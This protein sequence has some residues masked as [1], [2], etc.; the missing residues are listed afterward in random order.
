[1]TGH[2]RK[3]FILSRITE[4]NAGIKVLGPNFAS[5]SEYA[6]VVLGQ[7]QGRPL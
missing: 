1:M 7:S 3:H 2:V 4:T 6:E 5:C